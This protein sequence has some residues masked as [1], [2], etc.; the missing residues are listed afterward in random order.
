MDLRISGTTGVIKLDDFLSQRPRDK[1]ADFEYRQDWNKTELIEVTT[2]KPEAALMFEDFATMI[3]N[4]A[5]LEAS[6]TA[7]EQTQK[8]LDAIWNSA[9][10][11]ENA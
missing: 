1:P 3:G 8:L 5:L 6:A 2:T 7:S 11:N 4:P 9:I 10:R